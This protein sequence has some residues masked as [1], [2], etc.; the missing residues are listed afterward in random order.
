MAAESTGDGDGGITGFC[1]DIDGGGDGEGASND[2][3]GILVRTGRRSAPDCNSASSEEGFHSFC[4]NS[5]RARESLCIDTNDIMK[6]SVLVGGA[7][8]V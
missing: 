2:A 6:V 8:H 5:F 1:G 4:N 7:R 3:L